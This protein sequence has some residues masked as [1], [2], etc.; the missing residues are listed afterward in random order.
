MQKRSAKQKI[1]TL[2]ILVSLIMPL[3][4]PLTIPEP[5]EA[6]VFTNQEKALIR[7]LQND[8]AQ[9]DKT[10]YNSQNLYSIEPSLLDPF[11]PGALT[12]AYITAQMA[13]INY[14]RYLFDLPSI[15][16]NEA[17]NKSAQVTAAIMAAVNANP[18]VDQH[19]LE[20]VTKP[21]FVSQEDWQT[22]Q[23][24]SAASNL[25]FNVYDES[26]GEVVKDFVT[27]SYN[28][29]GAD[30]GHRAWILSTRASQTGIGAAYGT[31]GYRYSVQTA[32]FGN[33]IFR[34]PTKSSV[35]YPSSGVFPIELLQ[36]E[37]IAWSLYL[38]DQAVTGTPAI[39]I[40]DLDTGQTVNATNVGNYS[41]SHYGNFQTVITYYPGNINLVSGHAYQVNIQGILQY[42]FKLYNQ[43][44]ANQ[45]VYQEEK[46]KPVVPP[47]PT[48][49]AV[50]KLMEEAEALRDSLNSGRKINSIIF[51]RSYQDGQKF[52]NLGEKQWFQDYYYYR[53]PEIQA[54]ILAVPR[55]RVNLRIYNS[56]YP[57]HQKT[58]YARLLPQNSYAYGQ[59]IQYGDFTWY[60]IG[61]EQWVR[62]RTIKKIS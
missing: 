25:N 29:T 8:Y 59:K 62:E 2:L 6:A 41:S 40:K 21:D 42:T 55:G 43:V 27:D 17:D 5:V 22:A 46:P 34:Q 26:A 1:A 38:S 51:G 57:S 54:G 32:V 3:G 31:N 50:N 48:E 49:V 19:G 4:T 15:S 7:Q 14:Y 53:N 56:P 28:L 60:Y 9:L 20:N 18:F 24:V 33:D 12:P 16:S 39:T 35:P 23:Q 45:P 30:T 10:P 36:G 44:A 61:P 11:N 52:V 13:Y 47:T 37:N 58:T